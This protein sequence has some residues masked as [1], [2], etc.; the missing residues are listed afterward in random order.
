MSVFVD[1]SALLAVLDTDDQFHSRARTVWFTM[2][3]MPDF[4][5]RFAHIDNLPELISGLQPAPVGGLTTTAGVESRTIKRHC[6]ALYCC[7]PGL[8][9]TQISLCLKKSL[10]HVTPLK[11]SRGTPA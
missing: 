2:N 6:M 4:F 7:Y 11:R 8:E 10:S 3:L 5:A 1:T 9:L